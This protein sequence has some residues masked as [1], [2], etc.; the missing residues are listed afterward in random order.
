MAF[1]APLLLG[2]YDPGPIVR[3]RLNPLTIQ[4][5][6]FARHRDPTEWRGLTVD[7]LDFAEERARWRLYRIADPKHPSGPLW[8]VPHDDENAGFE[9]A[10]AALRK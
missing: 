1:V 8:F 5:D 4:T 6:D 2:A 3:T 10:L 7:R 9:A